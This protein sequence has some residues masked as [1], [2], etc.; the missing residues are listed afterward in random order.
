MN[1]EMRNKSASQKSVYF[2]IKK[3]LVQF[4]LQQ[5]AF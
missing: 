3:N 2:K 5:A 1:E 4:M